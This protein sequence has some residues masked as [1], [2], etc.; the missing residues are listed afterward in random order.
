V[1][2]ERSILARVRRALDQT[3]D[4]IQVILGPRQVGKTTAARQIAAGWAGPVRSSA[5]D[6]YLPPGPEWIR[7]TW[8][9]ARSDAH[10]DGRRSLLVLDEVQ[11]VPGWSEVVKALWDEDRAVDAPV[12]VLLLGSSALL[13]A[14][15]VSE[16]LAGRFRVHRFP[17][18]SWLE[19]RQAFGWTLDE[20]LWRGGYPGLARFGDD[21]AERS[22]YV[23]DALVEA[24]LARDVLALERVTKP[25]LLRQL[26]GLASR[27][28]AQV[29][30]FN[31]MLGQLQDAG[32]TTT[33]AHYLELLDRA[34]VVRGLPLFTPNAVRE[35]ASSPKL[36]L[37]NQAF[38]TCF[39]SRAFE[40]VRQDGVAWGRL[41]ENAV[42]AHLLA[43]VQGSGAALSWWRHGAD[44][45]DY[46]LA[47]DR[48]ITAIE[49]K[50]GRGGRLGGLATFCQRF[51]GARPVVIGAG[52]LSLEA[53]FADDDLLSTLL[54]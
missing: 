20:W 19:C 53:F 52:G 37:W 41:V 42:G 22:A 8:E 11:K 49:V 18:W 6:Q 35:R 28:P 31:K 29:L 15:G 30:A 2:F 10:R 33:L 34:F 1:L 51:E 36:V 44:E 9:L 13:L 23:R 4:L 25:A 54:G 45:V 43:Q 21:D 14:S 3:P 26:F 17:H 50:S 47:S 5:A 27:H 38:V 12:S 39:E 24:V 48:R 40:V 46:V 7:S 32:N 16:S